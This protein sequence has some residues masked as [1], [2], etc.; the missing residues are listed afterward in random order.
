MTKSTDTRTIRNFPVEAHR[1]AKVMAM[2]ADKTLGEFLAE[3]INKEWEVRKPLNNS[4]KAKR[5]LRGTYGKTHSRESVV[6]RSPEN[7]ETVFSSEYLPTRQIWQ[8]TIA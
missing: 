3:L 1:R 6:R 8:R 7:M 4:G 5:W 2:Y